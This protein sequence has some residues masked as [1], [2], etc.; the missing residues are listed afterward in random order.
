MYRASRVLLNLKG[1]YSSMMD[2][3]GVQSAASNTKIDMS[4]NNK[5]RAVALD[6]HLLTRNIDAHRKDK[7]LSISKNQQKK[8]EQKIG[9]VKPRT[10]VVNNIANLLGVK[11]GGDMQKNKR[12]DEDDDD[13]SLLLG[14]RNNESNKKDEK[15]NENKTESNP[16]N[17][18]IRAK[19]AKKLRDK[20]DGGLAGVELANSKKDEILKMGDAKG[21]LVA[22]KIAAAETV[23]KSGSKWLATTGSG[24][25]LS[26]LH[27][28]SMKIAL[29]P[30]PKALSLEEKDKVLQ[31]MESLQRQLPNIKIDFL[32]AGET[33][34]EQVSLKLLN[35]L[36][37]QSDIDP[38]ATL[39]VSDQDAYLRTARDEGY[40]TC[41]VRPKN[42]PR[43]NITTNFTTENVSEVQD[44]VN[45]L[46]GISF[47]TVFSS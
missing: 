38:I 4:K 27:M 18:D 41:R 7:G 10:N 16:F 31:D 5:I 2:L 42:A 35:K 6:F 13:L 32:L 44:V 46:V 20:V 22:R 36:T 40:Y 15:A 39:V 11:L 33:E 37:K 45:E 23:S 3:G 43:G 28:R 29:L 24:T 26:F 8:E 19:Y 34:S 14:K 47:N 30:P 21:H 9:D 17:S 12:K 25:L 1:R